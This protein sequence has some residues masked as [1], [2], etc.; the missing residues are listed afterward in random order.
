MTFKTGQPH[1]IIFAMFSADVVKQN[2][3]KSTA[4]F[5]LNSFYIS[6]KTGR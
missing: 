3:Q 5:A 4:L 6:L 2:A 1:I